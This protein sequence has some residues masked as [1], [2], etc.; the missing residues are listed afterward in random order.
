VNS[1]VSALGIAA[2]KPVLTAL[3][4]PPVPLLFAIVIGAWMMRPRPGA[5][6]RRGMWLVMAGV[7]GLWLS[8]CSGFAGVLQAQLL[9]ASP[10]LSAARLAE[11]KSQAP[12]A[13]GKPGIAIVVLGGGAEPYAPEYGGGSLSRESL[14]RLRYGLWLGRQSGW[15]VAF[16]GGLGWA[17]RAGEP[18]A[19]I[20]ARIAREDFQQPLRWVENASRD[21]RENAARTLPLLKQAGVTHIVLVTHGWHMQRALAMF[22]DAAAASDLHIEPAPMGLAES[23]QLPVLDWLPSSDGFRQTRL[24]LREWLGWRLGA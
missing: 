6:A 22:E 15:P 19:D 10:A 21:T 8:A 11:L 7:L 2:W 12:A 3:L 9:D 4:L 16:S 13:P 5:S 18:E 14:E 24:V 17:A 23:S 1:I 20:A